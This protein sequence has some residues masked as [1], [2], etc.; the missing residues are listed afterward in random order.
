MKVSVETASLAIKLPIVTVGMRRDADS[1]CSRHAF[2]AGIQPATESSCV[3]Q[4]AP[5]QNTTVAWL[6]SHGFHA[7]PRRLFPRPRVAVLLWSSTARHLKPRATSTSGYAVAL[8]PVVTLMVLLDCKM[9]FICLRRSDGTSPR[10][11]T[12]LSSDRFRTTQQLSEAS[13]VV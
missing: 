13:L 11:P 9:R 7:G 3:H 6:R 12:V 1:Q 2:D 5:M 4:V 8:Y 10:R